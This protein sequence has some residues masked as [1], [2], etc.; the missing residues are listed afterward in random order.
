[1]ISMFYVL[2]NSL[3]RNRIKYIFTFSILVHLIGVSWISESLITYGSINYVISYTITF[4]LITIISLPY[5]IIGIFYKSILGNNFVN[6]LFV[7]SLFVIA[8]YV[9]SLFFGGF[10]WLLL[11][12]SQNQTV[13]DFIYPIFG[14]TA[15]SYI[16]VLISAIVYKSIIDKT[17]I[18]SSVSLILLLSYLAMPSGTPFN[19]NNS[20]TLSY[21]IYQPNIYPNET[22]DKKVH[23]RII[24]KYNTILDN[25]RSSNIIIFPETILP[26]P[27]R[28]NSLLYDSFQSLTHKDN[29]LISGLFTS[30]KSDVYNSMVSF[31]D[32][33][34]VY[35]KRKLVPFGEYTPWY[36]S[37]FELSKVLNIPLSNISHGERKHKNISLADIDVI[38]MICFESTSSSL[39]QSQSNNEVIINISNDGW[40]GHTL[41]PYQHLQITQIRALE[42]NRFILRG[43]N[44]GISA[45]IDNHGHILDSLENDSEGI[46]K[47]EIPTKLDRS[48]Y[49]QYGDIW[50]L[51]LI[52]LSL[53]ANVF[54]K[55]VRNYE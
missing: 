18:Y 31:S 46:L 30:S 6:I 14:S 2:D 17:R 20:E 48:L 44:T 43:T 34:Q 42:F 15:V 50:I 40:F 38:P 4:L 3:T 39:I 47:G 41:A 37:L 28:K 19:Y 10:S 53:L 7:S 55:A 36:D 27:F 33:I 9:K 52:F 16:I 21:T 22:Y 8:E 51:M 12:Q 25:N 35:N 45:V 32:T 29:V 1:M 13:F 5:I 26:I 23:T 24:K 54:N 11:G 49:S